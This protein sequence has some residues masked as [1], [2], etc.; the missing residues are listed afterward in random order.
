MNPITNEPA[1]YL[2][3]KD[4]LVIADLHIGIEYE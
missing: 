2:K 3:D 1:L 4:L